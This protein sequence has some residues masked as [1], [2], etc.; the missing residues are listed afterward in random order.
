MLHLVVLILFV[1]LLASLSLLV[2]SHCRSHSDGHC[3]CFVGLA[4]SCN[5]PW[6]RRG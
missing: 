2:H 5:S 1:V 4:L 3:R 6:Q